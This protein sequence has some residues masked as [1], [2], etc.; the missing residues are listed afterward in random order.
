MR[1][2]IHVAALGSLPTEWLSPGSYRRHS[3]A[4]GFRPFPQCSK[5]TG[6]LLAGGERAPAGE[7]FSAKIGRGNY[8]KTQADKPLPSAR[9]LRALILEDNRQDV[10]LMVALLKRVGY[11]LSFEVLDSLAPL[12]QQLAQADYDIILAAHNLRA[13]TAMDALEILKKSKK[14]VPFVVV[15]KTLG[16]LAAVEYIKRGAAD[17][18]LKHQPSCWWRT[19]RES[20]TWQEGFW[21]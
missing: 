14:D 19:R 21:N 4:G 18:V 6:A 1:G 17:Y 3:E 2:C 5:A 15:A 16:G 13:W 8:E 20:G 11:A 9:S 12:Q 10:E 7:R